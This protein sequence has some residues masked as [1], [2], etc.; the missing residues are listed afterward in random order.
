MTPDLRVIDASSELPA[1]GNHFLI[2]GPAGVLEAILDYPE[3]SGAVE[4]I[5]V[6]CHPHP[7]YGGAMSNKVAHTVAKAFCRLGAM[8]LRFNFRGVGHSEGRFDQGRGEAQDLL[9]VVDWLRQRYPQGSL[10]LAGFSFGAF[11]AYSAHRQAGA[12]RLLLVAPPV[13]MFE[14]SPKQTVDVPWMVIQGGAD[15]VVNPD[16]VTRWVAQQAKPAR[17]EYFDEAS[18]F[19][20]GCL[21][22]LRER[23]LQAWA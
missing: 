6:V 18:H 3:A 13:D 12:D 7:L 17:Y 14:F 1:P 10:W 22:P 20:H 21:V 23:I 5:A 9:A 19:F 4:T 11:V 2:S 16:S 8:T 15:E